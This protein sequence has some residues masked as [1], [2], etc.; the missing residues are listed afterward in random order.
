M[1]EW[2]QGGFIPILGKGKRATVRVESFRAY[3]EKAH[4]EARREPLQH[5]LEGDFIRRHR[6]DL[7]EFLKRRGGRS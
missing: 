5:A 6:D 7:P 1:L 4:E 3:R 2:K